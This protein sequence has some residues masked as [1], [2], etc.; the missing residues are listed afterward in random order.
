[1][2][3]GN[4]DSL[5]KAPVHMVNGSTEEDWHQHTLGGGWIYRTAYVDDSVY[6]GPNAIVSGTANVYDK[7]IIDGKA[8]IK[9]NVILNC[10]ILVC[11][12][13]IVGGNTVLSGEGKISGFTC[14]Y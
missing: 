12:Y 7:C 13:A 8:W 1:M 3:P 14:I 11:D 5:N 9:D 10:Q 2:N 4:Y 6:V